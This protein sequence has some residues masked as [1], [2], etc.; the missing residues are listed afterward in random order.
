M[1]IIPVQ[2]SDWKLSFDFIVHEL[3]PTHWMNIIH[4]T[5]TGQ[6]QNSKGRRTPAVWIRPNQNNMSW[7]LWKGS[8]HITHKILFSLNTWHSFEIVY[9]RYCNDFHQ[10]VVTLDGI[11][12]YQNNQLLSEVFSN[13][14]CYASDPWYPPLKGLIKNLNYKYMHNIGIV[15]RLFCFVKKKCKV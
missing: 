15:E 10:V 14:K 8:A 5:A 4:C 11:V 2:A 6:D 9:R 3:H 7:H 13:V 12:V 1:N